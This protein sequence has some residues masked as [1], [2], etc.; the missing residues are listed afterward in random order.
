MPGLSYYGE[1][2]VL[3][4]AYHIVG[5]VS[6]LQQQN[7]ARSGLNSSESAAYF[8]HF[9][10]LSCILSPCSYAKDKMDTIALVLCLCHRPKVCWVGVYQRGM[11][12]SSP[13]LT[14]GSWL[15][16]KLVISWLPAEYGNRQLQ[17]N[18]LLSQMR[19]QLTE[20]QLVRVEAPC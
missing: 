12:Q 4:R 17:L 19:A 16:G 2:V 7:T 10:R 20:V 14:F 9:L 8:F 11:I 3:L 15:L 5:R 13:F 6:S 18:F 1:D